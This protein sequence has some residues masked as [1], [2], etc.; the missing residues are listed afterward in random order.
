MSGRG[1]SDDS[2]ACLLD[3]VP[4]CCQWPH[5]KKR[6]QACNMEMRRNPICCHMRLKVLV[7]MSQ[8]VKMA[9]EHAQMQTHNTGAIRSESWL[10][11]NASTHGV[12]CSAS[13]KQQDRHVKATPPQRLESCVHAL[14]SLMTASPRLHCPAACP[15]PAATHLRWPNDTSRPV[16]LREQ[17]ERQCLAMACIKSD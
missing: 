15:Q 14:H 1:W 17:T 6:L 9:I 5:A 10:Q 3:S 2:S 11:I 16:Q 8:L 13:T 4:C 7:R 12:G